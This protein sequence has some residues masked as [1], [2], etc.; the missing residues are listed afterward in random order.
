MKEPNSPIRGMHAS[1]ITTDYISKRDY[2]KL[3]RII[4][5]KKIKNLLNKITIYEVQLADISWNQNNG[6]IINILYIDITV[7]KKN[8]DNCFLGINYASNFMFIYLFFF[9]IKVFDKTEK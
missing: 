2:K 3:K 6:L 1:M 9:T 4:M 8:L 5:W 7:N